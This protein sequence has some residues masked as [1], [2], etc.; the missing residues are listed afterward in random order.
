MSTP[1]LIALFHHRW[2]PPALA[3]LGERDGARFVELQRR[4]EVGRESLRPRARGAGRPGPRSARHGLRPPAAA[5]VPADRERG[6]G[7]SGVARAVLAPATT[8]LLLRKWSVPVL[9][10]LGDDRR[11]SELRV[12]LG[13]ITPRALALALQDLESA[14]LVRREVLPTRPP[15]T[16]YRATARGRRVHDAPLGRGRRPRPAYRRPSA[17]R[18][19]RAAR[20]ARAR[21]RSRGRFH[22]ASSAATPVP[23]VRDREHDVGAARRQLD[24][25]PDGHRA[26]ARSAAAR[27]R[28]AQAPSRAHPAAPPSRATTSPPCR[29]RPPARASTAAA[30][31]DRRDRRPRRAAPSAARAPP[32]SRGCG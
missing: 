27:R 19:C 32:R 14:R 3:L 22:A 28:R 1:E 20:R 2:A 30:R 18:A 26:R 11:F 4:L 10:E 17:A 31:S 29:R 12:A 24:A 8:T 21:A 5:R 13:E 7:G 15:S 6:A 16:V 25:R 23:V 9:A